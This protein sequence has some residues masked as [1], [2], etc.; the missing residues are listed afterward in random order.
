[1]VKHW[2]RKPGLSFFGT[3]G[4]GVIPIY[5]KKQSRMRM[6]HAPFFSLVKHDREI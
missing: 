1:M 2:A 6:E 5:N 4:V 3:E